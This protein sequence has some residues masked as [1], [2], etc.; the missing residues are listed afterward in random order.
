MK[1]NIY[2]KALAAIFVA[3]AIFAGCRKDTLAQEEEAVIL[4]YETLTGLIPNGSVTVSPEI[5]SGE[6][7]DFSISS[8]FLGEFAYKGGM[9]SIDSRTG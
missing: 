1:T 5:T 6:P 3:S 2:I 4:S 9:F 7:S 8:V